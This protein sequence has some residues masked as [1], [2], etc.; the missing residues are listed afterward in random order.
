M[1]RSRGGKERKKKEKKKKKRKKETHC[2]TQRC[3]RV[4]RN[5]G[6][7]CERDERAVIFGRREVIK[8][9]DDTLSS[10]ALFALQRTIKSARSS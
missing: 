7:R 8:A 3:S 10:G 1:Q 5:D 4:F 2:D 9:D 6:E